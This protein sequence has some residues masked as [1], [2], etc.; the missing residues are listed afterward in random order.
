MATE[1]PTDRFDDLPDDLARVGAHRAAPRRG[2]GWI[3]FAWAALA[4]GLLVVAGVAAITVLGESS[5]TADTGAGSSSAS[6]TPSTSGTAEAVLDPNVVITILNGT[7]TAGLATTVGDSLVSEGWGGAK[8]GV[9][10]RAS[11]DETTV[12]S[13]VVY[14][15]DAEYEGAARALVQTLGVGEATLSSSYPD[16]PITIVLGAD[17]VPPVG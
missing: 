16:T 17:Y 7:P 1:F 4:T 11:A 14:Y 2:R 15:G 8:V 3:A 6:A 5:N 13:T 9:G 12:Q 10:T